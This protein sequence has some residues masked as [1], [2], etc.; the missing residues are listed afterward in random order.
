MGLKVNE[1]TRTEVD[2]TRQSI[3][4]WKHDRCLKNFSSIAGSVP[5]SVWPPTEL[6]LPV[7]A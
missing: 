2:A 6:L 5:H 1:I 7:I 3:V 4:T